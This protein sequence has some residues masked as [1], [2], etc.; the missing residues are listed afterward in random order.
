MGQTIL[1]AHHL[2]GYIATMELAESGVSTSVDHF[3]ETA[4][5]FLTGE[6]VTTTAY[7]PVDISPKEVTPM[8]EARPMDAAARAAGGGGAA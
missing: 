4:S 5:P 3:M 2:D 1:G 6:T 7:R 8:Q